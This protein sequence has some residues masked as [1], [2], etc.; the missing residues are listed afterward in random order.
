MSSKPFTAKYRFDVGDKVRVSHLKHVFK[1]EYDERW[2]REVFVIVE[3]R[4][5]ENIPCYKLKDFDNEPVSGIF[6]ENEMQKVDV[7]DDAIYK[8]K[9]TLQR[10]VRGGVRELF[11]KWLGWP[12]KFNTWIRE[13]TSQ[14]IADA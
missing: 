10:R 12:S 5:K 8:I 7:D 6:Y 13:D 11:V 9:K 1:R 2:T 14:N 3:K 4:L